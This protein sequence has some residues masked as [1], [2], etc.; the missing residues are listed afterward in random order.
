MVPEILPQTT[1]SMRGRRYGPVDGRLLA[2]ETR[3]SPNFTNPTQ[4]TNQKM[5]AP[6][7]AYVEFSDLGQ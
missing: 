5:R 6:S 1:V 4:L 2:V 7:N 3:C